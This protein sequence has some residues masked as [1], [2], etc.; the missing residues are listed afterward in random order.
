MKRMLALTTM[1]LIALAVTAGAAPRPPR[2]GGVTA[3]APDATIQSEPAGPVMALNGDNIGTHYARGSTLN[4][5]VFV[6]DPLTT[7]WT[8][9]EKAA[10]AALAKQAKDWYLSIAPAS[11]NLTFDNPGST[12]YYSYEVDSPVPIYFQGMR[13]SLTDS[14]LVLL[15]FDDTDGDGG[16]GDEAT[17]YLQTWNGGWDNV[18]LTFCPKANSGGSNWARNLYSV[19]ALYNDAPWE[20]WA[21]EW[22]HQFGGCDEDTNSCDSSL[23]NVV[24]SFADEY[25]DGPVSNGNCP[26]PCGPGLPC[27]MAD[28]HS[29]TDTP[30]DYTLDG[31]GWNDEDGNGLL[32]THQRRVSGSTFVDIRELREDSPLYVNDVTNGFVYSQ[33]WTSW[34]VAGL[35]SPPSANYNLLLFGDNN[36]NFQY[37]SSS[38]GIGSVDFVVADYNHSRLG[39]EHLE[40]DRASGDNANYRLH[41]ESGN[42]NLYP[43]GVVRSF[44]L[45]SSDVV[46][47]WDVP[48]F[49]GE[50]LSFTL[51]VTSGTADLGMALYKSSGAPYWVSRLSSQKIADAAVAGGTEGFT[52]LVPADDVYGLVVWSNVGTTGTYTIKIGPTPVALEEEIP[53]NSGLDLRLFSYTPNANAW[54]FLGTRPEPTTDATL[55]LYSDSANQNELA[56]SDDYGLGQ[57]E[58]VAVDYNHLSIAFP[59]YLRVVRT[60]GAGT[61]RTEWEQDDDVLAGAISGTWTM[62]YVG[63]VWDTQLT[64][65]QPYLF[66]EYH[67][68]TDDLDTGIYLFGSDDAEYYKPRSAFAGASNVRAP[69][70]GGEWFSFT[71]ATTD[72]YGAVLLVNDES[73]G[74]YGLWIGP[75]GTLAEEAVTTRLEE[76]LFGTAT[77]PTPHWTAF[78]V[79]PAAGEIGSIWLY[80]DAAYTLSTLA[81]KDEFGTGVNYVVGDYNHI[82]TGLVYPRFRR[83]TGTGPLDCQWEGGTDTVMFI[84]GGARQLDLSWPAGG[85]VNA[86]DLFIDGGVMGG[87]TVRI[88][89]SDLSGGMDLGVALFKSSG[90]AWYGAHADAVAKVDAAGV[91][92]TETITYH[93][94]ATDWYGLVVFNQNDAGGAYRIDI[95]DGVAVSAPEPGPVPF[96]LRASPNPAFGPSEVVFGLPAPGRS[97]IVVYDVQGRQ[98]RLLEDAERPAGEHRVHWDG[99]DDAGRPLGPGV[100]V[101][102]LSAGGLT[103]TIKVA[104]TR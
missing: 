11:A 3:V 57:I 75:K 38:L 49:Q 91:G 55:K 102:R 39:L 46:K 69:N 19:C 7:D 80:G 26:D 90:A 50:W 5:I 14:C 83:A 54:A 70:A 72:W 86:R 51:D 92:G 43:D 64:A 47:V 40:I 28:P 9:A 34:A 76:V 48:L 36:H 44:S 60:A 27:I 84:P 16:S 85:V 56:V 97:E 24:C 15:G 63:K 10:K 29:V 22:G 100:F 68:V 20:T 8:V 82:A 65:G 103:R 21:H 74:N 23:C 31:W 13:T 93:A 78:G 4:V 1:A 98:V 89:V 67:D 104:R 101:A 88:V 62:T 87:R 25:R 66:R 2:L 12:N 33:T 96:S 53:F 81:V 42:E 99:C 77:I 61:Y 94:N 37:A 30:C 18:I 45:A 59:D 41:W 71:P 58:F 52:Y 95:V 6:N 79:R 17:L 73:D 32:D 35:R